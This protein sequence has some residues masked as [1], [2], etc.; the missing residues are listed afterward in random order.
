MNVN[1]DFTTDFFDHL[2]HD[3]FFFGLLF[4]IFFCVNLLFPVSVWLTG[5]SRSHLS[6]AIKKDNISDEKLLDTY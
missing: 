6:K 1:F 2:I 4:T 5:L 3:S